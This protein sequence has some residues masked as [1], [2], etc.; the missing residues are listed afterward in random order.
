MRSSKEEF[1]PSPSNHQ[2]IL[3]SLSTR[4]VWKSTVCE[5]AHL[6]RIKYYGSSDKPLGRFLREQLFDQV[7]FFSSFTWLYTSFLVNPTST[8]LHW[9]DSFH[10]LELSL[11]FMRYA[12]RSTC[13]LL[14]TSSRQPYYFCEEASRNCFTR[15]ARRKNLDVAQVSAM[16][17]HQW[18]PSS[19]T[20]SSDVWCCM[21]FVFW[22][23]FGTQ[24]FKPCCCKQS[25]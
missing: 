11:P 17:S 16:S 2:S 3:V 24:L 18:V 20:Q 5:R 25:C 10:L 21:G 1:P 9:L 6:F 15:G 7:F 22:K 8:F 12:I 13:S 14:Y 23:I 19:N 4:C